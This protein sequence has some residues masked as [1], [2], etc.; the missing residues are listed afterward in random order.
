MK[1]LKYRFDEIISAVNMLPN[2]DDETPED[3]SPVLPNLTRDLHEVELHTAILCQSFKS[4]EVDDNF[5]PKISFVLV[6]SAMQ[7]IINNDNK[8]S[9][10][11][12]YALSIAV[13]VAWASGA[14]HTLFKILGLVSDIV[15]HAEHMDY[16]VEVPNNMM[17]V[18]KGNKGVNKFG[19]LDP[20][21]I[22]KRDYSPMEMVELTMD[23]GL[24]EEAR[25][26]F[27]GLGLDPDKKQ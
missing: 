17:A 19:N 3:F 1:D 18:F 10:D 7:N 25:K 9:D 12:M 5:A 24:V 13:N 23:G 6:N 20:Y 4:A 11:D 27:E 15:T 14:I 21:R 26:L 16:E 8:A 2:P 22:L